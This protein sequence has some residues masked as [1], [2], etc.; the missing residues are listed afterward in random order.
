MVLLLSSFHLFRPFPS[1]VSPSLSLPSASTFSPPFPVLV[2]CRGKLIILWIKCIV[3][4]FLVLLATNFG[5]TLFCACSA[6]L[7]MRS[8]QAHISQTA[9]FAE[10]M[11]GLVRV[12]D[13]RG[14]GVLWTNVI[15]AQTGGEDHYLSAE[16]F[17]LSSRVLEELGPL[18]LLQPAG[19]S[20]ENISVSLAEAWYAALSRCVCAWTRLIT[21]GNCIQSISIFGEDHSRFVCF[22]HKAFRFSFLSCC[23]LFYFRLKLSTWRLGKIS[24]NT[25]NKTLDFF[26]F[27]KDNWNMKLLT[28]WHQ[29]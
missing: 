20:A 14:G 8:S 2:V 24:A 3:V 18:L 15:W 17:L 13:Q 23:R 7:V 28:F 22:S 25:K 11:Y 6:S 29:S 27:F 10:W 26:V 9:L 5:G 1:L 21:K 12:A 4:F 16:G 19:L